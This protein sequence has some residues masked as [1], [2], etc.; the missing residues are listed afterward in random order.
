MSSSSDTTTRRKAMALVCESL[1]SNALQGSDGDTG[2]TGPTGP[3]SGFTGS[4]GVTGPTG[5]I[6]PTGFTGSTGLTGVSG[7][8]G[9]TGPT[10]STGFTGS[11]GVTGPTG[12]TGSTGPTGSTGST[13]VSG[14]TGFTGPTGPTGPTGAVGPTGIQGPAGRT[15][16]ASVVGNYYSLETQAIPYGVGATGVAF[17]F[18]RTS[19]EQGGVSLVA[20]S[21]ITV[22]KTAIYEAYYSIQVN[23]T[24]GGTSEYIYVWLRKN[25][26]DVPDSNG[27]VGTNS[28]N[29][30]SLPI[31]I[32][33]L[34]L[35]AGDYI[36]FASQA[37]AD[38]LQI[39]AITSGIPGPAIPSIIAGIKEI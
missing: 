21:R 36:E 29:G 19:V 6:G 38:H 12:F 37:S 8:T 33:V 5:Y 3:S 27:R 28:N 18:N 10:G 23:R 34:P 30:D 14:P 15:G 1:C 13:G 17:T 2:P 26:I 11:T 35:N 16:A 7:P 4:T 32:Y 25:G 20:N 9:F 39:L 24:S 22:S 31:V